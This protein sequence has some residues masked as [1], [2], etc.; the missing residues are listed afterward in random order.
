MVR[1]KITRIV[2]PRHGPCVLATPENDLA[3]QGPSRKGDKP[4]QQ[5]A[6]NGVDE[7]ACSANSEP[8]QPL[9][10]GDAGPPVAFVLSEARLM[11][12][13]AALSRG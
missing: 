13:H 4:P 11:R 2:E 7:H 8:V 9:A 6:P 12:E 5:R 3:A 1:R 10:S